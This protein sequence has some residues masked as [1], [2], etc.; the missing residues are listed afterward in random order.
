MLTLLQETLIQPGTEMRVLEVHRCPHKNPKE[1]EADE[2]K[3]KCV[4]IF[5][6]FVKYEL[7]TH[8]NTS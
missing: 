5:K 2:G 4:H 1:C 6:D 7:H 3:G 8:V